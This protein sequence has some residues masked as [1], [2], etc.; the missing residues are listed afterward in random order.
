MSKVIILGPKGKFGRAATAAFLQA[1]WQV[2]TFGRNFATPPAEGVRQV[3]GDVADLTSLRAACT[4][5]DVI[6]NATNPAYED[7]PQ[8]LPPLTASIIAAAQHANAT[9]IIPGNVYNYGAAAPEVLAEETLWKPTSRKGALRVVMENAYRDAGVKTIVLRCGDFI[10][11][12]KSG[13]WFDIMITSKSQAGQTCYP[14][15]LD[16]VHAWAYLPDV[17]RAAVMLAEKRA[18]F[19]PFEEFGFEGY[20]LTGAGLLEAISKATGKPQKVS[21]VPWFL[22]KLLGLVR[23]T[24]RELHEMRYLWNIPHRLEGA[25]LMRFLPDFRATPLDDAMRNVLAP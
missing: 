7:W 5:Q 13:G 8:K 2:T 15:P 12:A 19:G 3:T 25:K 10:E 22:L 20:S 21:G 6:V 4:G 11:H 17:A 9:V 18:E 14:G 23:P 24:I 1:G 16:R